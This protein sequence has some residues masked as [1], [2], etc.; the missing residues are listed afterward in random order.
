[1]PSGFRFCSVVIIFSFTFFRAVSLA[2]EEVEETEAL[3]VFLHGLF[4]DQFEQK[5]YKFVAES[6]WHW[7]LWQ[8]W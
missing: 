2:E 4:L 7:Q 3:A 1:M 5:K 8:P 6:N